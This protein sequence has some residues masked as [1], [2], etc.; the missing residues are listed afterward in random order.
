M[1]IDT[2]SIWLLALAAACGGAIG[3]LVGLR[4]GRREKK[5]KSTEP[6]AE[7]GI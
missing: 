4:L 5:K 6:Q 3:L 2:F 7:K 1:S